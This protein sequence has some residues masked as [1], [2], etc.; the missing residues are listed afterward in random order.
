MKTNKIEEILL[1][2]A[3][4]IAGNVILTSL[5]D[6]FAAIMPAMIIGSFI[7]LLL[8]FPVPAV[9][10]F[11]TST[12]GDNWKTFCNAIFAGTIPLVS[13]LAT[14]SITYHTAK[15]TNTDVVSTMLISMMIYFVLLPQAVF[16]VDGVA[17]VVNGSFSSN[18]M[19]ARG[20][21]IAILLGL[22]VPIVSKKLLSI[23]QLTIKLPDSVPPSIL[24]SFLILIPA[25]LILVVVSIIKI[26]ITSVAGTDFFTFIYSTFQ[27]PIRQIIGTSY[28]G[29]LLS[30]FFTYFAWFFGMHGGLLMGP[31]NSV[32]FGEL[33]PAN[34]EAFAA[35]LPIPNFFTG[36][37]FFEMFTK[38]GGG[39]NV[40]AL[41]IAVLIVAKTSEYRQV[42]K[43]GLI[44][45]LFNISEPM[46]FGLPV[47]MNPILIIPFL[48]APIVCFTLAYFVGSIGLIAPMV[49]QV[50]WTIPVGLMAYLSTAGDIVTKI[51]QVAMLALSV[52]IYIPFIRVSERASQKQRELCAVSND[53]M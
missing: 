16:N 17:N 40:L 30:I 1:P 24:K 4:K 22:L 5:R 28:L 33:M 50:P 32:V 31:I 27:T 6:G 13:L 36:V 29:G 51:F 7:T 9:G 11:L 15:N 47:V 8:N 2:F 14:V 20:F 35:G 39:G 37:P 23:K 46:V 3:S 45:S 12:F 21:F 41:V 26:T 10:Q 25:L 44:P 42:A 43:I 38:I 34:I 49:I 53:Q 48:I 19:G 52:V 18:Y